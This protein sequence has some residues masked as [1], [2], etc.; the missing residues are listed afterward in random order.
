M[1]KLLASSNA[2]EELTV[3]S[4][5]VIP[6]DKGVFHATEH[7]AKILRQT[8][9]FATVGTNFQGVKGYECLDCGRMNVFRDKCGKCGSQNLRREA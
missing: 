1:T 5:R 9:D 2:V 3:N 6:R 4:G 7:E 8:G